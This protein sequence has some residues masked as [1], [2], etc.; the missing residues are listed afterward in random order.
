[1]KKLLLAILF[2]AM[3]IP[4]V[5]FADSWRSP[6]HRYPRYG[7]GYYDRHYPY[8]SR[9]YRR[10]YYSDWRPYRRYYDRG[11]YRPYRDR[12]YGYYGHRW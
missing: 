11:H 1:M 10:H 5:S 6:Y 8:Y 7:Y 9:H 12:Y 3:L 4:S 2:A